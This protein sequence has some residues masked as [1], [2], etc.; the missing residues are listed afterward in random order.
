MSDSDGR[1]D[2]FRWWLR[3]QIALMLGG[4]AVGVAG[5]V[6][7]EDFVVGVAVGLLVGGLGLRFGR[8]A[9][10]DSPAAVRAGRAVGDREPETAEG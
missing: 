9:A 10:P 2:T 5:L 1:T 3:L 6:T 8:R 4:G 7:E